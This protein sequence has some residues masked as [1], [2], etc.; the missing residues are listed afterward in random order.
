MSLI[1]YLT[2]LPELDIYTSDFVGLEPQI[3]PVPVA[4][5]L[6]FA[7]H[8]QFYSPSCNLPTL[9][10][11]ADVVV[12]I[13]FRLPKLDDFLPKLRPPAALT[14]NSQPSHG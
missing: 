11:L 10:H 13:P 4:G 1:E 3:S 5:S 2:P 12:T 8:K 7:T 6:Q 9:F 14:P